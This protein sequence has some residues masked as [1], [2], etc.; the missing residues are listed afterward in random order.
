M[1]FHRVTGSRGYFQL[2]GCSNSVDDHH[3][4]RR[5]RKTTTV[6]RS[7]REPNGPAMESVRILDNLEPRWV[8]VLRFL[9]GHVE[10]KAISHFWQPNAVVRACSH[11]IV[12]FANSDATGEER[13]YHGGLHLLAED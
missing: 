13:A 2:C 7:S 5:T 11:G 1:D 3:I 12:L 9:F 10:F 4:I 8:S 6:C